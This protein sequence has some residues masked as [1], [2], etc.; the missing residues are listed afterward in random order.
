MY[1]NPD[2]NERSR[3]IP[4]KAD[5]DWDF[6]WN[7]FCLPGSVFVLRS[8]WTNVKVKPKLKVHKIYLST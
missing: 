4:V 5:C 8:I 2:N 1:W 3:G 6:I 7:G